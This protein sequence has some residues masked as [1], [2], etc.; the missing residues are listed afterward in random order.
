MRLHPS[1]NTDRKSSAQEFAKTRGIPKAYGTYAELAADPEVHNAISLTSVH[2][3]DYPLHNVLKHS[4]CFVDHLVPASQVDI[5]HLAMV[6]PGAFAG[7]E[8]APYRSAHDCW[9]RARSCYCNTG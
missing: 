4:R 8:S 6:H 9:M 1:L 7:S 3:F 2:C 5:V